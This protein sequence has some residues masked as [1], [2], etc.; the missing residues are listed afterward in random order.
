MSYTV[1]IISEKEKN[2]KLQRSQSDRKDT[3]CIYI[4]M[5]IIYDILI[6]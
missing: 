2:A 3:A 6:F 4:F 1:K 5:K